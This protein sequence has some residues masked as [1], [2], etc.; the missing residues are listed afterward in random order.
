[1]ITLH[2]RTHY[3]RERKNKRVED[4][5]CAEKWILTREKD[6]HNRFVYLRPS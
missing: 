6:I 4:I 1:M 5:Q 2:K 3:H